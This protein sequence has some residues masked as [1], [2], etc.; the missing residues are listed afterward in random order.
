MDFNKNVF[1]NCPLDNKY[2]PFLRCMIFTLVY[3]GLNPRLS[4]ETVDC[5][6]DRLTNILGMI[7]QSK[8]SIHDISMMQASKKNEI[9]RMNMPF[10]LG[11]DFGVANCEEDSCFSTKK[12][13]IMESDKYLYKK[14][15]SDLSGRDIYC[16]DY[17]SAKLVKIIRD[18]FVSCEAVTYSDGYN[19][20]YEQFVYLSSDVWDAMGEQ[21]KK[22]LACNEMPIPEY[23]RFAKSWVTTRQSNSKQ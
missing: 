20:I 22:G 19:E 5:S 2:D 9:F 12:L 21:G 10:E 3:L 7:K 6:K 13:L 17:D 11:I 18:W 4:S 16:H 8:Y 1:I 14:A 23:I 15:I